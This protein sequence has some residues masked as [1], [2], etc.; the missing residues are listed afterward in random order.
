MTSTLFSLCVILL[1]KP[2]VLENLQFSLKTI[3]FFLHFTAIPVSLVPSRTSFK[4]LRC[5]PQLG[6]FMITSA[7]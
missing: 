5:E 6:E 2:N 1:L 7:V 3:T 4:S